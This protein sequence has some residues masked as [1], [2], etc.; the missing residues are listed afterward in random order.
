MRKPSLL[1]AFAA[2][3]SISPAAA[4]TRHRPRVATPHA[5]TTKGQ[6][7]SSTWEGTYTF[8]EAEGRS[9]GA[10]VEHTLVVRRDGDGFIADIDADGFQTSRSLRCSANP[11][12]NKLSL[13]FQAYREGNITTPYRKG[14]L[15]LALEKTQVGGRSRLL[16][17]WAAYR[18]TLTTAPGGRVYFRRTK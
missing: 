9:A 7:D 10:F 6:A 8:Q 16:T 5:N 18:P 15:L 13:Y 2:A 3:A 12:G 11:E 4:Q 1:L 17:Y 14:Q